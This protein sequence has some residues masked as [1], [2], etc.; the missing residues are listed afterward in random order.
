M[1]YDGLQNSNAESGFI[2]TP[3]SPDRQTGIGLKPIKTKKVI[4]LSRLLSRN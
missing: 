4:G 2:E 3:S 1:N